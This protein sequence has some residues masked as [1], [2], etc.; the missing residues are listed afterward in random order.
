MNLFRYNEGLTRCKF[1]VW[2][3]QKKCMLDR[4]EK[5]KYH[6]RCTWLWYD[7]ETCTNPDAIESEKE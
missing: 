6:N 7:D 1:R 4:I 2:E 5:S 3:D